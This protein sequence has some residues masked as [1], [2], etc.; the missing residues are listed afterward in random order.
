[1]RAQYLGDGWDKVKLRGVPFNTG[2]GLNMAL[3]LGAQPYGS[4]STCHASPQ[5]SNRP[6]V[7]SPRTRCERRVLE[8]ILLSIW[9]YGE[10]Q[11]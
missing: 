8:P 4:W 11:R 7:R 10:R 1:M 5:D 6:R 2:D 3:A 9:D